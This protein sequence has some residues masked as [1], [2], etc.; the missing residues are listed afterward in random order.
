MGGSWVAILLLGL[1]VSSA[2]AEFSLGKS[3]RPLTGRAPSL[4]V[5]TDNVVPLVPVNTA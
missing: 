2:G 4:D 1:A 3:N 5:V